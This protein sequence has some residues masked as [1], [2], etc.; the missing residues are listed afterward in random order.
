MSRMKD[1]SDI[2][3]DRDLLA[4][5]GAQLHGWDPGVTA[6]LKETDRIRGQ[7]AGAFG[8]QLSFSRAEWTWL[9]PLLAE[10][11]ELRKGGNATSTHTDG[12]PAG[13][14]TSQTSSECAAWCRLRSPR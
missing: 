8:E 6:Y 10:L 5:F 7:G 2:V 12:C 4:E 13:F 11:R 3:A 14:G 9:R 1:E